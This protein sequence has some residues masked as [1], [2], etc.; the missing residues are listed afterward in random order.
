MTTK[1]LTALGLPLDMTNGTVALTV[2]S[3]LDWIARNTTF[4]L[5]PDKELPANVK[6]FLVKYT[7]LMTANGLVTSES[8]G[9]MS[10]SFTDATNYA[11]LLRQYA[12]ELL[13]DYYKS[14]SFTP[15]KRRWA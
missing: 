7:D 1:E 13:G 8:L 3:G 12:T 4:E 14:A 11:F 6:L 9:G 5:S 2:Q 15:A 10:Q